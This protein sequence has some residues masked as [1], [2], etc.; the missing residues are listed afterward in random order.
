MLHL[1]F[2]VLFLCQHPTA[3]HVITWQPLHQAGQIGKLGNKCLAE[4]THFS[5]LKIG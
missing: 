5:L 2:R 1:T 4:I 3:A